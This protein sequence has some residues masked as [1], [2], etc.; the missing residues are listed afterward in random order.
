MNDSAAQRLGKGLLYPACCPRT[1]P[2]IPLRFCASPC[3]SGGQVCSSSLLQQLVG[4]G[5]P[6]AW[7]LLP[8]GPLWKGVS[9]LLPGVDTDRAVD[10]WGVASCAACCGCCCCCTGLLGLGE[11]GT[12]PANGD[13]GGGRKESFAVS[14]AAQQ[15]RSQQLVGEGSLSSS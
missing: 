6:E 11:S 10:A 1:A 15:A 2:S 12:A 4:Q 5:S 3:T 9:T 8:T 13:A 7:L 14:G